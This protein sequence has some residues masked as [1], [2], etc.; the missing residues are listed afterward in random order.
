MYK[1][2]VRSLP[3]DHETGPWAP[4]TIKDKGGYWEDTVDRKLYRVDGDYLAMA[5]A[6]SPSRT[7]AIVN[8]M[9]PKVM[10]EYGVDNVTNPTYT[11]TDISWSINPNDWE[12][13]RFQLAEIIE[14]R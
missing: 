8:A 2:V 3:I 10:W 4:K 9:V 1:I 11:H 13:A 7:Q 5:N 14:G 6:I 12:N